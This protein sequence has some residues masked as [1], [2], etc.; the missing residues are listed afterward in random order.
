MENLKDFLAGNIKNINEPWKILYYLADA[1]VDLGEWEIVMINRETSERN[2]PF[3]YSLGYLS[4]KQKDSESDNNVRTL[5]QTITD[6]AGD[7]KDN[8]DVLCSLYILVTRISCSR[9]ETLYSDFLDLFDK[10]QITSLLTSFVSQLKILYTN[11]KLRNDQ[12]NNVQDWKGLFISAQYLESFSDPVHQFL[13]ISNRLTGNFQTV[14]LKWILELLPLARARAIDFWGVNIKATSE[15]VIEAIKEKPV[16]ACFFSTYI[17]ELSS[18]ED[19]PGWV[20]MAVIELL[21]NNYWPSA[22]CYILQSTYGM[23]YGAINVKLNA[24]LKLL[25]SEILTKLLIKGVDDDYG[26]LKEIQWPRDYISLTNWMMDEK[27]ELSVLNEKARLKLSNATVSVLNYFIETI[28]ETMASIG[29]SKADFFQLNDE[30]YQTTFPFLLFFLLDN[31]AC[32]EEFTKNFFQVRELYY[33]DWEA[34]RLAEDYTEFILITL[35]SL[36]RLNNLSQSQLKNYNILLQKF[37]DRLWYCCIL[38]AEHNEYIWNPA[39][40]F[41]ARFYNFSKYLINELILKLKNQ[42]QYNLEFN[43]LYDSFLLYKTALWPFEREKNQ[44]TSDI[45]NQ[46]L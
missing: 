42:P 14:E 43:K 32:C 1:K 37:I 17:T 38:Q 18:S 6:V 25:V 28:P 22:G 10:E 46:K 39:Y 44:V 24:K 3:E 29:S 8:G 45:L 21:I 13:I 4:L 35:L 9:E 30:K 27:I 7:Y 41:E 11:R 33:G 36:N 19:I 12:P 16:E 34:K 31:E 23:T 20:D 40:A 2:L 5:M 26:I 15:Q